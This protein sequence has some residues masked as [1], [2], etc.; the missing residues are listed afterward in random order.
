[1]MDTFGSG[2]WQLLAIVSGAFV[3]EDL[4]TV[5]V[6]LLVRAE[7][8]SWVVGLLG[9]FLGIF[10]SDVGLWLVGFLA[11][12]GLLRWRWIQRHLPH[13]MLGRYRKT[14][15][16]RGAVTLLAARFLPGTRVPIYVAAG[17][18]GQPLASFALWTGLAALLWTPLFVIA[19]VWLGEYFLMPFQYLVGP[20][21]PGYV[22]LV[23]ALI[24]VVRMAWRG[25]SPEGRNQLGVRI[26]RLWHWEFWPTWLAYLPLMPWLAYL[27]LR[28]RGMLVWTAANPGIPDGGVVGESKFAILQELRADHVLHA[29]LLSPGSVSERLALIRDG[30]ARGELTLP[31]I[32]KPDA[33]Q[34]GAGVKLV[35][36]MVDVA[37]YVQDQP[38]AIIAQEYHPGPYEAGI[39]YYRLPGEAR[40]R[41]FSITDKHFPEIVGDGRSTL[42]QLIGA[43]P[44]L[45]LQAPTFLARHDAQRDRILVAG[46]RLRLAIAGNHCQGTMFRDGRHLLTTELERTVDRI[47]RGFDGFYVGRFDVRYGD[48]A[49]FMAGT[50][51]AIVELNGVTAESTNVYDPSWSLWH[52][53]RTLGRQ[54]ELLYRIGHAN[55]QRGQTATA[56]GALLKQAFDYYANVKV[57]PLAD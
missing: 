35:H 26:E 11:Q 15:D 8:V 52:A 6:G 45:R 36:D 40:G 10:L 48:V 50:D 43:H 49:G 57:N 4:T 13:A 7:R 28:Y 5:T 31:F 44:R 25:A 22:A 54:W 38:A 34:R 29:I 21:W 2:W 47:A 41:I 56:L 32:M 23:I 37:K 39:F 19:V 1:M 9:S 53:Y 16:R 14:F 24:I 51:L 17:V 46:E 3:S 18:L 20:G 30:M 27:S 33:G 42:E 55:R 12:R